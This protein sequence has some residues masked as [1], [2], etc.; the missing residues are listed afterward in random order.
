MRRKLSHYLHKQYFMGKAVAT[1][2]FSH[3]T[4]ENSSHTLGKLPNNILKANNYTK[5]G[6]P[7]L[8]YKNSKVQN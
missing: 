8:F 1:S 7:T 4:S 3:L 2:D 6:Q 5:Q